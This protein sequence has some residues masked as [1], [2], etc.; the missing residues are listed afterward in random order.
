MGVV[1]TVFTAL[2][3]ELPQLAARWLK[4]CNVEKDVG[5]GSLFK[6]NPSKKL[7][8]KLDVLRSIGGLPAV[9]YVEVMSHF[10][11]VVTSC[12][13]N[14]LWP[15]YKDQIEIFKESFLSFLPTTPKV[16][17]IFYH[18]P[19]FCENTGRSLGHHSEQAVESVHAD[20]DSVWTNYK[21]GLSNSNYSH[22]L[23]RSVRA[24]NSKHMC[25]L[26]NFLLK[27]FHKFYYNPLRTLDFLVFYFTLNTSYL[28]V[29]NRSLLFIINNCYFY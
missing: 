28:K 6:G 19:E 14:I 24:Y 27:K 4:I 26:I 2:E 29:K 18:V 5:R 8:D 21:V 23:L 7:L 20:F 10:N 3:K 1:V 25:E 22:C 17:A 11:N 15:D 12:F 13:G 9:K 16:H